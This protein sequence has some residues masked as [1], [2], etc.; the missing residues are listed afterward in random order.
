MLL[1]GCSDAGYSVSEV[2][3][4]NAKRCLSLKQS[5][6]DLKVRMSSLSG[7]DDLK[8][9]DLIAIAHVMERE[10]EQKNQCLRTYTDPILK[11]DELSNELSDYL[12]DIST[13][14]SLIVVTI[15]EGYG[16]DD[17][18]VREALE[19]AMKYIGKD[20]V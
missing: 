10:I 19:F 6:H 15:E 13:A 1:S 5:R 18:R 17:P 2:E 11:T 9:R 12:S 20:D 3:L 4:E 14:R 8:E 7:R 16:V